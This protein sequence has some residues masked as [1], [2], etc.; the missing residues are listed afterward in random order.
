MIQQFH[1][2]VYISRKSKNA[3][4]KRYLH[5]S[6]RS[7]TVYNSQDIEASLSAY[8]RTHGLRRRVYIYSGILLNHKKN[9][10]LPFAAAW[11]SIENIMLYEIS[12]TKTNTV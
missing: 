7:S 6:I 10:T 9:E 4:S 2:W 12:Q 11:M 5:L 3:N 8:Q 1:F